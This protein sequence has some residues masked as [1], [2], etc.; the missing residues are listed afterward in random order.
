MMD[1]LPK[2]VRVGPH[3]IPFGLLTGK[4]AEECNGMYYDFQL[5]LQP[6]YKSGSIAVD[7]VLHELIHC[8]FKITGIAPKAGE[9]HIVS[10]LAPCLAQIIRDN[11][12]LIEWMQETVRK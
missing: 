5:L 7:I 3:N 12:E 1:G 4:E 11:P 6:T 9:E 8:V 10:A 2:T